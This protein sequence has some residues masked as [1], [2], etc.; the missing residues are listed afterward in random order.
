MPKKIELTVGLLGGLAY[1]LLFT[2]HLQ[3]QEKTMQIP[4][5]KIAIEWSG[6]KPSGTITV[7]NG[8]L[9]EIEIV[10]GDGKIKDNRFEFT[11]T[12]PARITLEFDD[13][14]NNPGPGAT[15]I[16]VKTDNSPFSFFLRDVSKE[17]PMLY[18]GL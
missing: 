9:T 8:S 13:V 12:G 6:G 4:P 5:Q 7:L 1:I 2:I 14:Q 17:F 16:S 3:G 18:S 15:I 10:K 11:G